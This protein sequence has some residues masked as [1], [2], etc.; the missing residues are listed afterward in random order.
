MLLNDKTKSIGT[1]SGLFSLLAAVGVVTHE[2]KM[3]SMINHQ[4]QGFV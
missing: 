4:F 3:V 1:T 2:Q